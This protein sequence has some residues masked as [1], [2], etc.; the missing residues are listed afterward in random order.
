MKHNLRLNKILATIHSYPTLSEANK[1]VA[2]EWKRKHVPQKLLNWVGKY[3]Q[4]VRGG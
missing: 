3:F 4:W 1:Y 2:G